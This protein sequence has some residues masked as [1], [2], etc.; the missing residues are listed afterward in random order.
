MDTP[1]RLQA[2]VSELGRRMGLSQLQMDPDGG[3]ALALDQRMTISLQYRQA[4]NELWL[5]ADLGPTPQ[6]TP[7]FYEQLLQANLFWRLTM[8]ATLSL[9]GDEPPH[10]VL[11]R[12]VHWASLD[13][14]GLGTALETFVN[15]VEDWQEQLANVED[16]GIAGAPPAD[17]M[18]LLTRMRA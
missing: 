16:D 17:S 9:S 14:T 4:E 8:G 2:L 6:R 15:T 13:D 1:D 7:A 12:P 10:L 11:A 3:C 5:Y 18:E